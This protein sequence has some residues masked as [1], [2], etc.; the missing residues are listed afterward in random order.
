MRRMV[1]RSGTIFGIAL[2]VVASLMLADDEARGQTTVP[3]NVGDTYFC[4]P[5]FANGICETNIAV[6]DTV[7]WNWVGGLPHTVTQCD[8]TFTICP[9]PGGFDSGTL[10]GAGS[11]FSQ[12]FN[13]A[14]TFPYQCNVHGAQ[15]RGRVVVA[16]AQA[17]PTATAGGTQPAQ[18]GTAAPTA[19]A[20]PAA[21][22]TRTAAAVTPAGVPGT[23]GGDADGG[24][25]WPLVLAVAGAV[26]IVSAG[27]GTAILRRR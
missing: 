26:L 12:T 13:A 15:M 18:T 19:S 17:T 23:G 1:L 16:A 20:A 6:G 14:G 21:T 24:P 4:D 27:A 22:A 8:P 10:T 11:T 9:P 3:V 7:M 5:S 25:S 2:A